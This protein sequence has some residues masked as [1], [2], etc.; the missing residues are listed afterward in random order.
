MTVVDLCLYI[1]DT[2]MTK[3]KKK[4]PQP[5]F[6]VKNSLI[7]GGIVLS[8]IV[9]TLLLRSSFA[10]PPKYSITATFTPTTGTWPTSILA[11]PMM[12]S[13]G[14][15][16]LTY[17]PDN[18]K[19]GPLFTV[20]AQASGLNSNTQAH[21]NIFCSQSY[22]VI[23]FVDNGPVTGG[24]EYIQPS[25]PVLINAPMN[26]IPGG[27]FANGNTTTDI[28][29]YSAAQTLDPTKPVK[30]IAQ[31]YVTQKIKSGWKITDVPVTQEFTLAPGE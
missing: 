17:S 15:Y 22:P 8:G 11:D 4:Q 18:T 5:F 2:V 13:K 19:Y 1:Y 14:N 21:G 29:I 26:S 9:G 20:N 16:L 3:P 6:N 24:W 23:K 12:Q 30:C 10:A 31:I 7:F 27:M 25:A 28:Y